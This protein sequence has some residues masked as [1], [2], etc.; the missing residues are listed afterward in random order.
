MAAQIKDI[1]A[2]KARIPAL[3]DSME[4]VAI[5]ARLGMLYTNR[6]LDSCYYFSSR[7]L[8]LA[9]RINDKAGEAEALNVLAFYYQEKANPYL[10]YRYIN[11]SLAIF[12]RL[13]NKPKICEV[14]MNIGVLLSYEGKLDQSLAQYQKAYELSNHLEQDS[15]RPLVL[16]NLAMAQS[17]MPQ[18]PDVT[19][20][21]LIDEAERLAG[22]QGNQRFMVIA[23]LTRTTTR[24]RSGA[25]P[26]EVIPQQY[27]VIAKTKEAGYE[28]FTALAYMELANMF[29]PIALDS[30]IHYF[31][32]ASELADRTGYQGL[33][34]QTMTQAYRALSQVQPLPPQAN[35]YSRKLLEL[36]RNKELENQKTGMDFLQLALKEQQVA[37][38]EAR[39]QSRRMLG[40]SLGVICLLAIGFSLL[41]CYLYRN[42]RRLAKRQRE[43]NSRLEEQY[44]QLEDNNSFHQKL[45][46]IISHDLRQPL[47]SMLMLGEGGMI[48]QMSDSQRQYVFDQVS[49]NARTSLQAMDGL[50]HWMKLNTVGLAYT[51]S[52]VN[53]KEVILAALAYN[54]VVADQKGI[55]IMDF[56]PGTIGVL[57]QSEMLLFVNR[58]IL[59]NALRHTPNGGRIVISVVKEEGSNDAM[60]RVA[61]SGSG[62]SPNLL[63]HLFDKEQSDRA[64]GGS[65][66]AL[67]ICHEMIERMNGRIWANNNPD[68]GA[69]FC[70]TLPLAP[71]VGEDVP[72]NL[73]S[74]AE[75]HTQSID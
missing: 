17:F 69:S 45:I 18:S 31:G 54:Q 53:L 63:P 44:R 20:F 3:R 49:Q 39:L 25:S 33:H 22:K 34:F 2:L 41:V 72:R 68:G 42:K 60:V 9:K 12:E 43:V 57:A 30:A 46:S 13:K 52:T 58:N 11:E 62:I 37:A 28:Y 8:D 32:Q 66:L 48:D 15:I 59:S 26:D 38:D 71:P 14:T 67:I 56:I 74:P 47:S 73:P 61:D 19:P 23:E 50:V 27:A 40:I 16:L 36:S 35:M 6:S 4:Q 24:F 10:A 51:P 5:Y 7:A 55:A 64:S 75:T 29:L 1:T 70:Y 21:Q 65:G